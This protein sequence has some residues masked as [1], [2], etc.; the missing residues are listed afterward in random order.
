MPKGELFIRSLRRNYL[1]EWVVSEWE[2]A[3]TEYGI[4]FSDVSLSR[5]MTPAPK[6]EVL[7]NKSRLQHG[8]RIV[9]NGTYAKTDE[10]NVSIEMHISAP[11]KAT[12]W[13][14]YGGFC[15]NYLSTGYIEIAH[16]DIIHADIT[17]SEEE[18]ATFTVGGK[19]YS[20]LSVFRMT[21]VS[22]EEFTEFRQQLAR[23][24]LTLNEPDPDNRGGEDKWATEE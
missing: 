17:D 16:A 18:G 14:R 21:Y 10:R 6:K 5:L 2:D 23:Y 22:C 7:E 20:G 11:D 15:K 4:S 9:R 13:S 1:G 24:T 12:F 19:T 8:K 3:F